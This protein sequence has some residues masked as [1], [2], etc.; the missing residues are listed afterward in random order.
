MADEYYT[1]IECFELLANATSEELFGR[2][3]TSERGRA[4][5]VAP[6]SRRGSE[7]IERCRTR[8]ITVR[9]THQ[10]RTDR[11]PHDGQ[12]A[13]PNGPAGTLLARADQA[14]E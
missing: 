9:P 1:L 2:E 11:Q 14:S 8:R 6:S 13:R 12:K 3:M 10:V 7:G 5:G 4:R